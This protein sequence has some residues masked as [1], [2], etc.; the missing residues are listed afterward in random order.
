MKK[1][2]VKH[3]AQQKKAAKMNQTSASKKDPKNK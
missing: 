1:I 3:K 2:V